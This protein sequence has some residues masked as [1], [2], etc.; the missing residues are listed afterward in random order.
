MHKFSRDDVLKDNKIYKFLLKRFGDEI[1]RN[2]IFFIK[3]AQHFSER[4]DIFP[5]SV[6]ELL[7]EF[8][9]NC[10]VNTNGYII[11]T[12]NRELD[13][14]M[15]DKILIET[16]NGG[17]K[18]VNEINDDIKHYAAGSISQVYRIKYENMDC[19][20]KMK[21][22]HLTEKVVKKQENVLRSFFYVSNIFLGY[23][24]DINNLINLIEIQL[25][26][27]VE[28][29]SIKRFGELYKDNPRV[30]IPK[31][32]HN[33]KSIIIMSY[34]KGNS[35]NELKL[36]DLVEAH[37][38]LLI[39]VYQ[40]IFI[41]K[42]FNSDFHSG[43]IRYRKETK[44]VIIYDFGLMIELNDAIIEQFLCMMLCP[45][46]S[47]IDVLTKPGGFFT[48]ENALSI[49]N[50]KKNIGRCD[51]YYYR[52]SNSS[53]MKHLVLYMNKFGAVIDTI[54][55]TFLISLL[56]TYVI[57]GQNKEI[58]DGIS[59]SST[60]NAYMLVKAKQLTEKQEIYVD[61]YNF[62]DHYDRRFGL[63]ERVDQYNKLSIERIK[64]K[65]KHDIDIQCHKLK[66]FETYT[67]S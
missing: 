64:Q 17:Y 63:Q 27:D 37:D 35:L 22:E 48:F 52:P 67:T 16:N 36:D 13:D 18:C 43:N 62:C 45:P 30:V 57:C 46:S 38:M 9:E 65:F 33:T 2:G 53:Y 23:N 40:S 8:R 32:Y 20:M 55:F 7:G 42:Y 28:S 21:H 31:H 4:I 19:I 60:F 49:S 6:C 3:I 26:F 24:I 10:G 25:D 50:L 66:D 39:F 54:Y 1:R 47:I 15:I 5:N 12:I 41:N 29:K 61:L 44:Q 34:E 14:E 56:S 11:N 59:D 51:E 58:N